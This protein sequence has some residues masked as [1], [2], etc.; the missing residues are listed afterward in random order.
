MLKLLLKKV[1]YFPRFRGIGIIKN[2][3]NKKTKSIII[4]NSIS[5]IPNKLN[6]LKNFLSNSISTTSFC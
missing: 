5:N 1:N 4:K 3:V 6:H 2:L